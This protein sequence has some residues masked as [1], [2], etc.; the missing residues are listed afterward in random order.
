MVVGSGQSGAQIADELRAAGRQVYLSVSSAGRLPRR[1]RGREIMD[2]IRIFRGWEQTVDQLETPAAR[3]AARPHVTGKDGGRTLNLRRFGRD[4]IVLVGKIEGARGD[5]LWLAPDV[6]DNLKKADAFAIGL[7]K[8]IDA[9][10]DKTG[11]DADVASDDELVPETWQPREA[12]RELSLRDAGITSMIW[13]TGYPFSF[14][15]I[16]GL[17][18]DDIGYPVHQRGVTRIPGL[19]F[20]SLPWMHKHK[21]CSLYGAAADAEHVAQQIVARAGGGA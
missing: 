19:Y 5:Q 20:A 21:S 2:W 6:H 12:I 15:W 9:G 7:C 4:G 16:V 10:I 18:V 8:A 13:A 14:D 1:Y 17:A 3:I 11:L